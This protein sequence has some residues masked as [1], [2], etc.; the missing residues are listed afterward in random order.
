MGKFAFPFLIHSCKHRLKCKQK[1][2]NRQSQLLALLVLS[3]ILIEPKQLQQ[4]PIPQLAFK[5]QV[6]HQ[7]TLNQ[8]QTTP[9]PTLQAPRQL[10]PLKDLPQLAASKAHTNSMECVRFTLLSAPSSIQ[11]KEHANLVPKPT[12]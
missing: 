3:R 10:H 6:I 1:H 9:T 8:L 11:L 4:Q 7:T 2:L 5:Q 12:L